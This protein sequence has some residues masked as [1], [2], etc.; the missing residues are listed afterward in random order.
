MPTKSQLLT[1][2]ITILLIAG[3]MRVPQA[4]SMILGTG[5]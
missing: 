2:G 4:R 1:S 3:L 5:A